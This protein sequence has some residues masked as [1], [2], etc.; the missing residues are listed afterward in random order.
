MKYDKKIMIVTDL[1]AIFFPYIVNDIVSSFQMIAPIVGVIVLN[2]QKKQTDKEKNRANNL[3]GYFLNRLLS[4]YSMYMFSVNS[5]DENGYS[6]YNVLKKHNLEYKEFSDINAPETIQYIKSCNVDI[7]LAMT[8]QI[9]KKDALSSVNIACI[10]RHPGKLPEYAGMLPI[11]WTM[12]DNINTSDNCITLYQTIHTMTEKIDAGYILYEQ[13]YEVDRN[14]SMVSAYALVFKDLANCF[15]K[16]VSNLLENNMIE[17]DVSK[18]MYRSHPD[19]KECHIFHKYYKI[20]RIK[21]L[22][23]NFGLKI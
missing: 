12:Y 3:Y 20:Y 23:N 22:F 18:R 8:H 13:K 10:N 6:L 1:D 4:A 17:Q 19:K 5:K 11:F 7:I 14:I 21:E 16:G 9:L 15:V 2:K